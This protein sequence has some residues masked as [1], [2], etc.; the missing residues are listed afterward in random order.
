MNN[1]GFT[2]I[3]LLAVIAVLIVIAGITVSKINTS[4]NKAA[5]SAYNKQ[6]NLIETAAKKW[7]AE[8]DDKLPDVGDNSVV[9]VDFNTLID[10][11][12]LTNEKILNPMTKE[13]LIGCVRISYDV[14]YNQY[15]YKYSD[16]ILD[17]ENYNINNLYGE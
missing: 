7:G 5:K 17:C 3:E 13:E 9:T 15:E 12:Y 8:N 1:K 6:I 2:L 4:I 16:N 10:A 11:G 14:E